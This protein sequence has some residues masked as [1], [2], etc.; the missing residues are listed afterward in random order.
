[1]LG[2]LVSILVVSLIGAGL[3]AMLVVAE[4]FVA[5]YGPCEIDINGRR[6][7]T[8]QGGRS[9]L[10]LLAEQKVYLSSACG[11]RG[12]CGTCKVKV[13]EGGGPV[14]ATETPFLTAAEQQGHV[15][16]SC[17]VKVRGNLVLE[18]PQSLLSVRAFTAVCARI[19][20]LTYDTR[21]FTLELRDPPEMDYIPGQYIQLECPRTKD[22]EPVSRAYSIASNPAHKDRIDLIIRRVP[23]G[24][25]TTYCFDYL[26]TGHPMRFTGPFGD[27]HLSET[28]APM[29]FIAGGSG[30]A[31]F[32]SI[33]HHMV[34]TGCTRTVHYFFGGREVRDLF[35]Q[36]QMKGFES[37]LPAFRFVPVVARPGPGEHWTGEQGLVTEAVGRTFSDLS[38][39]EGY[40]C[41]SPGLIEAS[42]KVLTGLGIPEDRVYYDKFS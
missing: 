7:L 12:T 17:Q 27:F 24:I 40:L 11:G 35:L 15:R 29:V 5:D 4:R 39:H 19:E 21:R 32:V 2:I 37:R 33:L 18:V 10:A 23:K 28:D 1:M 30:M 13:L 3:A 14:L 31:P 36:D 20:D 9:L 26:K 22:N 38:G 42:I 16:L 6:R 25:C 34:E 41:G 8:V